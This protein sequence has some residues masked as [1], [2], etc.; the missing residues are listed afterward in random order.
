[1]RPQGGSCGAVPLRGASSAQFKH[2][3]TESRQFHGPVPP[4]SRK[5]AGMNALDGMRVD[6]P[7]ISYCWLALL[8]A[9]LLVV[10]L[11]KGVQPRRPPVLECTPLFGGLMKFLRSPM[12][13]L[14]E[15]Y[16]L[17]GEVFTV[18]VLHH[19][20]TILVGPNVTA[21]FFKAEDRLMS[22]KEVYKFIVP[23]FGRGVV[24]DVDAGVMKEQFRMVR[25]AL[26]PGRLRECVGR[27][28]LEVDEFCS[29]LPVR[30]DMDLGREMADLVT[31]T[32]CRALLGKEV[33]EAGVLEDLKYLLHMSDKG[34]HPISMVL[35]QL[36]IAAH[37]KRD[38]AR[39]KL[40][41][42]FRKVLKSR[43][44]SGAREEDL[45]QTLM[46]SKY[47]KNFGGRALRDEEIAGLL[48]AALYAGQHT[49]TITSS[50]TG[51]QLIHNKEW[52]DKAVEE[53]KRVIE[54][55]EDSMGYD[56]LMD[57]PVLSK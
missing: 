23:T 50:W 8:S 11:L 10:K 6:S 53:Q 40:I 20:V 46:D 31:K 15:G 19:K 48:I 22:Q 28:R 25:D 32:T 21:H 44:E 51:Y 4:P 29:R 13:M 7:C 33:R 27:F 47:E 56:A 42:T 38:A 1:M 17:H 2:H 49:S 18:G 39:E 9:L 34:M 26:R 41:E 5:I 3:S 35:P 45:L 12:R 52:W 43:R 57:M 24:Y 37:R 30:G 54:E 16:Q 14:Q 36:P 55:Y